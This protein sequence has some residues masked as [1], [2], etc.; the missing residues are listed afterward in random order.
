[1]S[2]KPGINIIVGPNASGKTNILEAIFFL[3]TTKPLSSHYLAD[4]MY[5]NSSESH[6]EAIV[7]DSQN[8][9]HLLNINLSQA[10]SLMR[11]SYLVGKVR[12]SRRHFLEEFNA[13]FF[14]PN[15]LNFIS[16]RP[17]R[18][19]RVIDRFLASVDWDY[20]QSLNTYKKIVRQRNNL[21]FQIR[22]QGSSLNKLWPWNKSLVKYSQL[23]QTKRQELIEFFNQIQRSKQTSIRL[24]FKKS[25]V[26][27]ELINKADNLKREVEAAAS[28][29]G[30][31]RDDFIFQ[32]SG[33][34][35]SRFGSRGQQRLAFFEFFINQKDWLI[36][37]K[38]QRP[39]LLLDDIFSELDDDYIKKFLTQ[40]ADCQVIISDIFHRQ[41]LAGNINWLAV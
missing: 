35:L 24:E 36:K 40:M 27:Q 11:Q 2:F 13:L 31:H 6:L 8:Y 29:W 20:Y 7:I 22:S 9:E 25:P 4:L 38:K 1:M 26:S 12:V 23:I 34:P 39:I 14:E 33:Q 16:G 15:D 19:R 5:R 30:P 28:L 18:R 10:D 17:S 21:L 41:D 32:W 3:A 37:F